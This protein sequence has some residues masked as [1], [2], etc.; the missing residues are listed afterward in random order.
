[1]KRLNL[2]IAYAREDKELINRLEKHLVP[3]KRLD[4]INIWHDGLIEPGGNWNEEIKARLASS[5]IILL[6]ISIDF[7]ASD[8]CYEVELKESLTRHNRNEVKLIPIILSHCDW[9]DTVF[10]GL[11][12]LPADGRPVVSK[13]WV[14]QEEALYNIAVNIKNVTLNILNTKEEEKKQVELTLEEQKKELNN[15]TENVLKQKE[16]LKK[17][18]KQKNT[19][20]DNKILIVI[21]AVS[22]IISLL[23]FYIFYKKGPS[24]NFT[25]IMTFC[26]VVVILAALTIKYWAKAIGQHQIYSAIFYKFNNLIKNEIYRLNNLSDT[27]ETAIILSLKKTSQITSDLISKSL[28][29]T[30]GKNIKVKIYHFPDNSPNNRIFR[31]LS[32]SKNAHPSEQ[33]FIDHSIDENTHFS[34]IVNYGQEYFISNNLEKFIQNYYN[35]SGKHFRIS[36]S[37][38][39]K[40][41]NSIILVPIRI[42]SKTNQNLDKSNFDLLGFI[43]CYGREK[44]SFKQYEQRGQINTINAFAEGLCYYLE[45]VSNLTNRLK[46]K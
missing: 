24:L 15:V 43:C 6:M 42:E 13:H 44:D 31:V 22:L 45:I 4:L 18:P 38:W 30:T 16:I 8:Y 28:S 9:E 25:L 14:T 26:I 17:L 33:F 5:D 2:F 3:L 40:W 1:M 20:F 46:Q 32:I 12:V 34:L 23:S 39:G 36:D 21:V 29:Q 41:S 27:D 37:G 10:S 11:Q 7:I 19:I 35:D